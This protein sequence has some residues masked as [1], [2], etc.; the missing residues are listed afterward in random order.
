[1][2]FIYPR[3]NYSMSLRKILIGVFYFFSKTFVPKKLIEIF[4]T[5]QIFL[6]DNARSGLQFILSDLPMGS[7]VG[8]QPLTCP[9]V[10]ESIENAGCEVVF[11]DIN[12][13]FLIDE[14]SLK[15]KIDSINALIVTHTFGAVCDI[16]RIRSIAGDK[17]LIEDCSHA[18]LSRFEDINL[19]GK[20]ADFSLFSFG[21]AKFPSAVRGG[22]VIV[23]NGNYISHFQKKYSGLKDCRMFEKIANLMRM[24]ILPVFNFPFIYSTF[25]YK[26]KERKRLS[27]KYLKPNQTKTIKKGFGM[28]LHILNYELHNIEYNLNLQQSNA[29]KILTSLQKNKLFRVEGFSNKRNYFLVPALTSNPENFIKYMSLCGIEVGRHFV[30]SRQIISSYEYVKGDCPNYECIVNELITIPS[31]YEYKNQKIDL[32]VNLIKNYK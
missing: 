7:K 11:I 10:L 29:N 15:D 26:L 14:N 1:M 16:D 8:V 4:K 21:F 25:T 20:K 2:S 13:Q 12:Y 27:F 9:T 28:N 31:H 17:I 19:A 6:F 32:S 23:N 30:Q 5:D 18:F 24:I 22:F 3:L